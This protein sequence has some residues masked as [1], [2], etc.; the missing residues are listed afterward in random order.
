MAQTMAANHGFDHF[1]AD[2]FFTRNGRY[3]FNPRKADQ[4]HAWCLDRAK[5][6]MTHGRTCVV[7][8]TFSQQWEIQPYLNAAK[9]MGYAVQ[10]IE[11]Q[12]KWKNCHGVPD[13]VIEKMR[14]RWENV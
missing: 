4:A 12:G 9:E 11:A 2:Q 13:H 5:E 3:L 8:N 10:I 14:A 1:E 7:S 6:S